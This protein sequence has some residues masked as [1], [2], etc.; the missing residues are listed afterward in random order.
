MNDL[1]QH[2]KL[3]R[4]FATLLSYPAQDVVFEAADCIAN[5]R[6]VNREAS[7]SFESFVRFIEANDINRIEEAFTRT[8]D[9]QPLCHPYV[10]YQLCG[11]SQQRTMFILKL[12]ELYDEFSFVSDNELP[13]HL[14]EVLRFVGSINNQKCRN[15]I[16]QD[17]LLPALEKISLGNESDTQPYLALL[18]ALQLFLADAAATISERLPDD[19]QKE[20]LS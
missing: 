3:C 1:Q 8:F 18:D 11:E 15:E 4:Q 6:Q 16:I 5:L 2:Q 10:G 12:R 9:L 14:S 7:Q 17:G 19:R 20:C 13:D